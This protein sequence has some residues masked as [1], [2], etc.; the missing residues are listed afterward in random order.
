MKRF[1]KVLLGILTM[2]LLATP[3]VSAAPD[4]NGLQ[5]EKKQAEQELQK[6]QNEFTTIMEKIQDI[7]EQMVEK[8]EQILKATSD[9]EEAEIQEKEQYEAVKRC[10][11]A[12]Y[13]NGNNTLVASIFES[14]SIADMLKR[15]ETVQAIHSYEKQQL[16]SYIDTK[17]KIA[18]LKSTLEEEMENL[19]ALQTEFESEKEVFAQRMSEKKAELAELD[20]EIEEAVRLAAEEAARREEEKRREEERKEEENKQNNSNNNGDH[21]NS[22]NGN[23]QN[24]NNSSNNGGSSSGGYTGTGDASVGASIVAAAR[25]YIGVPYSWGGTSYNGIDCSGLTMM[26]HAAVGI[27]IPRVSGSQAA[28]GK[29]ISSLE[30]ALPGDVICYPGHVAI[31]TG[32]YRV[33]HAPT[34]GQTVKEASVY[35]NS[36]QPIIAI[37]RYW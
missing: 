36:S 3:T 6:L 7:E 29:S 17:K 32:N 1:K 11:V 26:A 19:Q 30:A 23:H 20:V 37:R 35:M 18:N 5:Q 33:I 15:A 28:S 27:S 34:F 13:E 9:L 22:D 2:S 25:S 21:N 8:G 10:I 14:G 4:V 24:G 12:M 31:Y 16:Q